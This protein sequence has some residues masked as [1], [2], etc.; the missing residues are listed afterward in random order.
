[1]LKMTLPIML[2][3][4]LVSP[5]CESHFQNGI[6]EITDAHGTRTLHQQFHDGQMGR[7]GKGGLFRAQLEDGSTIVIWN[8]EATEPSP[9]DS[10]QK[11]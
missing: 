2:A 10:K 7:I 3:A 6:V 9:S 8:K 4:L 1:M 5:S 11:K